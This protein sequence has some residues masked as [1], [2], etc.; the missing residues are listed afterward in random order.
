MPPLFS[1]AFELRGADFPVFSCVE[2]KKNFLGGVFLVK[3]V[4]LLQ[5]DGLYWCG[6]HCSSIT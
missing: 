4:L 5:F 2:E 1:T 6:E 3:N